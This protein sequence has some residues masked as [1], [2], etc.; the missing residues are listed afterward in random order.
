MIEQN[1][2]TNPLSPFPVLP[3]SHVSCEQSVSE[4][5]QFRPTP[6]STHISLTDTVARWQRFSQCERSRDVL[7]DGQ[8]V[9]SMRSFQGN[10]ENFLGTI[11]IPVGLAGPLR[12]NGLYAQ[13]D[14]VIPLATTEAALVASYHRG[15]QL[16]TE[17][18]GCSARLLDEAVGRA[19]GFVFRSLAECQ[20][21]AQWVEEQKELLKSEARKTTRYGELINVRPVIEGN[22]LYLH[23]NFST[24][25]A[26]GQN[27]VTIATEA[28]CA[29]IVAHCPLQPEYFFVEANFSGDKK[30]SA[31]SLQTVRGRKVSAEIVIPPELVHTHLHTTPER[32]EDYWRVG[33]IGAALSGTLGLQ[34]HFANGLAALY[35]AC[36]QDVACVAESAVG[37]TRFEVNSQGALY[38]AVTLPNVIVGTV[39]GGTGLPSQHACL[40]LMNLAGPGRARALA[41]VCAALCLA[42]EL[43]LVAALCAGHFA[44]AH[45]RLA[46][47]R[48]AAEKRAQHG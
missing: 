24:A 13:G 15:T 3:G 39:G 41:E 35:L 16:M 14:Y 30:A 10:I 22:H 38:A 33:S 5:E 31:Q 43:S 19:P 12:V 26:A 34:G 27:I 17:V 11:K 1:Q 40:E 18:G 21:F 9:E 44:R 46:R 37:V 48:V 7:L 4:T 36:G 6:C 20:V 47:D 29:Y 23:C 32:M 8:T 45:K 28:L 42:G 25:D 2:R